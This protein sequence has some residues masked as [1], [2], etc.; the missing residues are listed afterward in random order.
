[1]A[2]FAA[3][4]LTKGNIPRQL[5]QFAWP[6]VLAN[7]LQTLFGLTDMLIVGRLLGRDAMS[8]VTIGGQST[9]FLLTFSLGLTA[10][11]QIYIA[12]LKG[13]K[14]SEEQGRTVK[15]LF[16]LSLIAGI[17]AA[18][19]GFFLA[20]GM[21]RLLQT[22]EE[23]LEGAR[24]YMQI[25]SLGLLPAFLYNAA[26]GALRGQGDGKRPLVFAAVAAVLHLGLGLLFVGIFSM[27]ISG[28]ALATVIAQGTAALL[29]LI[30]LSA[31]RWRPMDFVCRRTVYAPMLKILKIGLPFGFQMC[32]L[33]LSALFVTRLV[34]PYG[35]AASAALGAGSRVASLF[36]VPMMA[37]GNAASTMV[38]QNLG[39][40]DSKRAAAAIRWALVY[41]LAFATVT[42]ALALLFPARFLAVFT[43]DPEVLK[44][45]TQYLV[46]LAWSYAGH[47]LHSGF[48]AAMLGAGR[49]M[50]SL[51]AAGAEALAGRMG[52]TWVFAGLWSLAGMFVAQAIAPYLAAALSIGYYATVRW[53]N[54]SQVYKNTS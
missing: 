37:I 54:S 3:R 21:L 5:A 49:T 28:A 14:K 38:G 9:L 2:Y 27:G 40:G 17:A 24:Q 43:G 19:L 23:A 11:G 51:S 6:L 33:N 32:L 48:N 47:A 4:D 1:M 25:T 12:Q 44:I 10:G 15:A 30:S 20:P 18:S 8:A 36:V 39:A 7:L 22:P 42:T 50:Y 29:G 46:I 41:A 34:N 52:L 16:L 53:R 13:A 45:G 26:G 35:V 31:H